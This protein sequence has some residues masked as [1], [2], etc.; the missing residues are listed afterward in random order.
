VSSK[1]FL[2]P[3]A[4]S[5]LDRL[6]AALRSR[7]KQSLKELE[8]SPKSK[9]ERLKGSPFWRLR[10][11][12]YRGSTTM[13]ISIRQRIRRVHGT[14]RRGSFSIVRLSLRASG[15][16]SLKDQVTVPTLNGAGNIPSHGRDR[17]RELSK[18]CSGM[19]LLQTAV[20]KN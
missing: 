4:A 9:G 6:H 10:V 18:V 11:G 3:R 7:M 16:H 2:H 12:E 13:P 20:A 5:F 17:I 15:R 14:Q 19:Y 8:D 1:V